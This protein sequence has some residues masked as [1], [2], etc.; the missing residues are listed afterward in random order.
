MKLPIVAILN[1][2][3]DNKIMTVILIALLTFCGIKLFEAK[4]KVVKQDCTYYIEQNKQLVNALIGIKKDLSEMQSTS[5][6]FDFES[7]DIAFATAIT[8]SYDTIPRRRVSNQSQQQVRLKLIMY[9]IDTLLNRIKQDSIKQK[10][11]L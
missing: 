10:N 6:N 9:R 11:N 4:A 5:F 2:I 7:D 3:K 1:W 8:A